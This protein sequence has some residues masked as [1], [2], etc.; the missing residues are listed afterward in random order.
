[1]IKYGENLILTEKKI[2]K[3]N[4]RKRYDE[5]DLKDIY[6]QISKEKGVIDLLDKERGRVDMKIKSLY[7]Y[8]QFLE[9]ISS[10]KELFNDN[11]DMLLRQKILSKSNYDLKKQVH[12][13]EQKI[14]DLKN[15]K[16]RLKKDKEDKLL[17]LNNEI[18]KLQE[19]LDITERDKSILQQ[20]IDSGMI[21]VHKQMLDLAK[22]LMAIDNLYD[23]CSKN[24]YSIRIDK[25]DDSSKYKSKKNSKDTIEKDQDTYK[26]KCMIAKENLQSIK[27]FAESFQQILRYASNK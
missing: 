14:E 27:Q 4:E 26:Y 9:Q 2:K 19:E 24:T 25:V 20:E 3:T 18:A 1:M 11:N 22:L 6:E 13:N 5:T 7:K 15:A 17:Q 12:M 10:S 23:R 8:E 16:T 21:N